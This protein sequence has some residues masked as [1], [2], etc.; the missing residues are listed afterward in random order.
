MFLGE[1]LHFG[2]NLFGE[3]GPINAITSLSRRPWN[4]RLVTDVNYN[5][6]TI[7]ITD[8]NMQ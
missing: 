1:I 7:T 6:I 8:V 5:L 4:D 2:L 3:A